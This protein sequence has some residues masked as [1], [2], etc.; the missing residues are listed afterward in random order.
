METLNLSPSA[1]AAT[2]GHFPFG[3]PRPLQAAAIE[4]VLDAWKS[5]IRYVFL[6]AP[7]GFGK[8]AV[9]VTLAR[10]NPKAYILVS[11]KTLQQQYV[12]EPAFGAVRA[13]GRSNFG[14]MLSKGR[15]CEA[16]LCQM[17]MEC[18]HK[19]GRAS[20]G[21]PAGSRMLAETSKDRLWIGTGEYLCR[22]WEQKCGALNHGCPV[23]NYS[24]FLHETHYAKD[25]G[26]R[27]L[28][29]CD[30][31]HNME[32]SLMGFISFSISDRDLK[33][34]NCR[35]PRE[36]LS[37]PDWIGKLREWEEL[38]SAERDS[39]NERMKNTA[40]LQ[41]REKLLKKFRNLSEKAGKSASTAESLSRKPKNWVI[42]T[43][44]KKK[45][46]KVT[47][48]PVFV[49]EWSHM[50]FDMADIFLMQSATIIDADAMAKSL[51]LP[52]D[53]CLF[54]RAGSTFD[55]GRRPIYY[56]PLGSMAHRE[57][58]DNLPTLARAVRELME[59]YPDRKGVIH[60]HTYMIQDYL[61]RKI[62][63]DR[64]VYNRDAEKRDQ[65]I[66]Q[67]IASRHP[68]V[69][70]TPS[71]YEGMDFRDDICRWQVLCKIPYPFLGDSQVRKRK[72][73]DARWYKWK[74]ILRLVQTYGRGMRSEK[75]WC[76]TY[77]FDSSF[78]PLF[79]NNRELFPDWFTEALREEGV[80]S[81]K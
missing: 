15:T 64:F 40:N 66:R 56:M 28:L 44:I 73:H 26:K 60:T 39:T 33:P 51:G 30:E 6:E 62:K 38:L 8:S 76:D 36:G 77:L 21:E 50:F 22:Y 63:S 16:G 72:E 71:A 23:M 67:F 61:V 55:P 69:L 48:R 68:L 13:M 10:E 24:Y 5:G 79:R 43:E 11:T 58:E 17:G 49:R 75:D 65:V 3:K 29:I 54:V 35:I 34:V 47:F 31:A 78:A 52:P 80:G 70:V 1:G 7:T 74:S 59:M 32:D 2:S 45:N 42:D 19:P 81:S 18:R 14:C 25:F 46:M 12:G 53:E 9:A 57:M 27:R 4:A 20:E 41:D 37:I